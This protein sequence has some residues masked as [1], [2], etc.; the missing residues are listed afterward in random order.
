METY[1]YYRAYLLSLSWA[2]Q[3]SRDVA[4]DAYCLRD[5][6]AAIGTAIKETLS[7]NRNTW[8][9]TSSQ[10]TFAVILRQQENEASVL[11]GLSDKELLFHVCRVF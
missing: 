6:A 3:M 10:H 7:R 8:I 2:P 4:V 1:K 5:K 11:S 9:V